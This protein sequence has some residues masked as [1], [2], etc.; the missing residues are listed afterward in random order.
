MFLVFYLS[1]YTK[2]RYS[3]TF[4]CP[5]PYNALL[6]VK[7]RRG[8]LQ[9]REETKAS[10]QRLQ[11]LDILVMEDSQ[12]NLEVAR[13]ILNDNQIGRF[14]VPAWQGDSRLKYCVF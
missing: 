14:A 10:K 3:Q 8:E 12:L 13:D 2:V 9:R 1:S 4:H 6:E 7:R 11:G 5:I